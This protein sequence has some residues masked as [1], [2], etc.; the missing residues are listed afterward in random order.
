MAEVFETPEERARHDAASYP[1][2]SRHVQGFA[3]RIAA[4]S[5]RLIRALRCMTE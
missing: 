4:F 5:S 1:K 2:A 3:V